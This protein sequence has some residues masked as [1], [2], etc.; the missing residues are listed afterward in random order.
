MSLRPLRAAVE[1]W[2]PGRG[3]PADP[4]QAIAAAWP[5]IVGDHVAGHSAPVGIAGNA[6]VIATRSSAWSQQLQFLSVAILAGVNALPTGRAIARVTFRSAA[7][8]A[9]SGTRHDA[10]PLPPARQPPRG[11]EPEAAVD[12]WDALER[13]RRRMGRMRARAGAGCRSCGASLGPGAAERCPPCLGRAET[14]R[15]VA[16][17]RALYMTPWLGYTETREEVPGLAPA[18]FERARRH[19]LQR[20]WLILERA[21]RAKR[22]SASGFERQIASSYVLLQSRL[23]PDRIGPAIVRNVLGPEVEALV[24]GTPAD[25]SNTTGR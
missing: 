21:R 19:L 1:S 6:L 8:R 3:L 25:S 24:W 13:V 15:F 22:V 12:L 18:E 17:Q 7:L 14:E 2:Q 23:P 11:P 5:A 9:G 4:V 16:A 20:W 10:A